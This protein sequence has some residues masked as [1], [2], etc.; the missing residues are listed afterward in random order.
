MM[1]KFLLTRRSMLY[2]LVGMLLT[3]M[4][5]LWGCGG[6]GS[7]SDGSYPNPVDPA[8][9]TTT[10]TKSGNALVSAD[11]LKQWYDEG[12][13]NAPFGNIDRVVILHLGTNAAAPNYASGHIP[14]A[15]LIAGGSGAFMDNARA[16][17][18]FNTTGAMVCTG[19]TIDALIQAAGID[20]N[21]TIVL[22]TDTTSTINMTR[23][24]ATLRYWGFAKNRIKVLQGGNA[25]W[26]AAGYELTKAVPQITTSAYSVAPGNTTRINTDVRA[27]LSEMITYVK[28]IADGNADNVTIVDNIRPATHITNTTDLI[29]PGNT[30]MEGAIKG[31]YRYPYGDFVTT[32]LYFKDADTIKAELSNTEAFDKSPMTDAKRDATKVF[33]TQCRA[34]NAASVGYF[35][36]D[37]IAYYNSPNVSV[38]WYD[39]SYGQW[40]LLVSKDKTGVSGTNAGGQLAVGSIWDT[41]LLMD[42]LTYTV[43]KSPAVAVVNYSNRVITPEPSFAAGNQIE[44]EDR[45]YRSAPASSGG[46]GGGG[47]GGSGC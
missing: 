6:S 14:G 31:S 44:V 19:K 45:A 2:S 25:A 23:A 29:D 33:I 16:E 35:A 46:G 24:Y 8:K 18:P 30:V 28:G 39:G 11:E 10:V 32:G 36:L 43:D 7:S 9:I 17:G 5:T 15:Q 42:N 37:G 13:V 47:G 3:A 12:K 38:K 20:G 26:I 40:N 21:T 4:L 41:T 22:T 1:H 27:S 34:G